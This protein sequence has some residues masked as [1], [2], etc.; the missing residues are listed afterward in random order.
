MVDLYYLGGRMSRNNTA[1]VQQVIV[2]R[3]ITTDLAGN[4]VKPIVF[5]NS[6]FDE[7]A[8]EAFH[9]FADNKNSRHNMNRCIKWCE[10]I[11]D[12]T[13]DTALE[14]LNAVRNL[15][16][17]RARDGDKV[18]TI[19]T[20]WSALKAFLRYLAIKVE[21]LS[22]AINVALSNV[23]A[24]A[25]AMNPKKPLTRPASEVVDA[26][27]IPRRDNLTPTAKWATAILFAIY[28]GVLSIDSVYDMTKEETLSMCKRNPQLQEPTEI[29]ALNRHVVAYEDAISYRSCAELRYDDIPESHERWII[30]SHAITGALALN[31]LRATE[32]VLVQVHM[33]NPTNYVLNVP[34]NKSKQRDIIVQENTRHVLRA[35][36]EIARQRNTPYLTLR[37]NGFML[38]SSKLDKPLNRVTIWNHCTKAGLDIDGGIYSDASKTGTH[39]HA[40]RATVATEMLRWGHDVPYVSDY[41]GHNDPRTTQSYK[42]RYTDSDT[43]LKQIGE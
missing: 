23:N 28:K 7:T 3:P 14:W 22:E 24:P 39:P 13:Y 15:M 5:D 34:F 20:T 29:K 6:I 12:N 38:S 35:A 37:L 1:T 9:A 26:F 43:H 32:I 8:L 4:L 21:P 31:A 36:Q 17:L 27:H 25:S 41:L 42:R 19:A 33:Y 11:K 2:T 10:P 30:L 16:V 18:N 40:V